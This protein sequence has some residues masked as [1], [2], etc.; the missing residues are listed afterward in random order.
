MEIFT[1]D[2]LNASLASS[3]ITV[4]Q[5]IQGGILKCSPATPLYE[6]AARMSTER[7]S[8]IIIYE[9]EEA[10]GIWTE[11]D[12]LALD[13]SSEDILNSPISELMSS[14]V[15]AVNGNASLQAVAS[16]F[17]SEGVRH[18]LVIDEKSVPL[19]VVSQ[20][21][22]VLNQGVEHYLRMRNVDSVLKEGVLIADEGESLGA[23]A[24]MMRGHNSDA[25][26]IRYADGELG[27]LTERD[28]VRYIAERRTANSV[29][30]LASRPLI[31]VD[32]DCS[33]Y[34]ARSML[35]SNKVR[36][37]G[38][39]GAEGDV[40]GV[41]SF[42]DIL[43]GM[44]H[45]Y[46][47]ELRQALAERD[48]ALQLSQKNLHLAEKV[49]ES[50]LEGIVIT[51]A[52]GIIESVNPAFTRLTGFSEEE[53][54]G[55]TPAML[56]SGRH[57]KAFY[58]EMWQQI[59]KEGHWQGEVWNRRKNGEVYPELL[60][61][62][63]IYDEG[64]ELTHYAALFSDISELKENEE[65][66][67]SLAYYD[68]LTNL[69][70]RRLFNDRLSVAISH[71]HRNQTKLAVLFVD[72]DRFKRINDSLG[73]AVGDQLLQEVTARLQK[74]IRED[75]TVARMGGD[76]FIILLSDV[77]SV[78]A[79]VQV[80]RRII[81]LMTES[82]VL[83]GRKLVVTCS[84]GISFYPDDA[85]ELSELVQN[86]D[87]AMYRAKDSGRNSYQLY[88][89]NMNV[90]SLEHLALEVALH[91]A[92][93]QG[94]LSVHLQPIFCAREETIL[95]AEALIRWNSPE[96]GWV[97]PSD[98]IP[99][100]EETGFIVEIGKFTLQ[101]VCHYLSDWNA[102]GTG[103][104]SVAVNVSAIQFR[105]EKFIEDVKEILDCCHI[106]P[107][108]LCFE[109]TESMLVED[110]VENLRTMDT[111]RDMGIRLAVDDFGTGYSSLNY[112]RRFP[113]DKLKIDRAF[114]RDIDNNDQDAALVE[115][116]IG[117]G[118]SL[119]LQV[120][121]EGVEREDQLR[122]LQHNGCDL[123]QGFYYNSAMEPEELE[124]Q[125]LT[126]NA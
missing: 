28:I 111:L 107:G 19:G 84:V 29:G 125:Y 77:E 114:I 69:P 24:A 48:K 52:D 17:L 102:R 122:V 51:D 105:S 7:C 100:A 47:Q 119:R 88:S 118:H 79:V 16:R 80:A 96:L 74:A 120:V 55:N 35:V 43:F 61:I 87:T 101:R 98:F 83:G 64:G 63:A 66:I 58:A 76:E 81:E 95:S 1:D 20:T 36:H 6:V 110:A 85:T 93:E 21:D 94:E 10:I 15:K 56:S 34:R 40:L 113:I 97:P 72:L 37:I 18:Y 46:V 75:D 32:S 4:A 124:R 12:A 89:P 65:R 22:I 23:I 68:P 106:L 121:A 67:R 91:K 117:L 116:V 14:P 38:V 109:L 26:L 5:I 60:T 11:R 108:Q 49:I 39:Y 71:A 104:I 27:I 50:S 54:L 70:N 9:G 126:T 30:T 3:E 115:A 2:E 33:L 45:V 42:S 112:L 13:F 82:V 103:E 31:T 78:D 73:H 57:S 123:I 62:A 90:Q 53:A 99:L 86:A 59:K 44:E 8:S 25:V 41:V 92:L